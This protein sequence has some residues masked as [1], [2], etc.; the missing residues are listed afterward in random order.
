[1]FF[2]AGNVVFPLILGRAA[3]AETSSALLGIAVS[4]VLCPLLGLIAMIYA[5]GD[6]KVFLRRLGRWPSFI[7]QVILNLSI[8]LFVVSRLFVLMHVSMKTF[9]PTLSLEL[10][11]GMISV[12][13]FFLA[14]KPHRIIHLL[15]TVLTPVLLLILSVLIAAGIWGAP[16]L[17]Y[18]EGHGAEAAILGLKCGYQ[19]MDLMSALVF[20]SLVIPPL[21]NSQTNG[22]QTQPI[23]KTMLGA[24]SIAAALLLVTYAGLV[25]VAAHYGSQ[26]PSS[27]PSEELLSALAFK[28]L[29]PY[30]EIISSLIVFFACLTTAISSASIF[31]K[32]LRTDILKEKVGPNLAL[33][34]ALGMASLIAMLGFAKIMQL[35]TPVA[36]LLYPA[37]IALCLLNIGNRIQTV[38]A[39]VFFILGFG[40]GILYIS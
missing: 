5:R 32:F 3:G 33:I 10:F 18:S 22:A 15:G 37:L 25:W 9:F 29:G 13:L 28:I 17:P 40:A 23:F 14:Y 4:G 39:P 2:G 11:S 24:S 1:M 12:F 6:L 19:M 35:M 27:I 34:I 26:L 8:G 20:S 38:R 21:L 30:G 16:S 36:E 7:C 31:A